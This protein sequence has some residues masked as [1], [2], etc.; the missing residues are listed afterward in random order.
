MA[1]NSVVKEHGQAVCRGFT[2]GSR[3]PCAHGLKGALEMNR[4]ILVD[5]ITGVLLALRGWR[6]GMLEALQHPGQPTQL[7]AALCPSQLSEV[8]LDVPGQKSKNCL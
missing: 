7:E 6:P 1:V 4:G 3:G 8:L 5:T 2:T